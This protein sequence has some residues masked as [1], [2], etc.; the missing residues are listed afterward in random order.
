[1]SEAL[2]FV[3]VGG[4]VA[5]LLSGFP[6]ALALGG[7]SILVALLGHLVN[8]VDL[9][10]LGALPGR[11]VS[12]MVNETLVAVPLFVFMGT[13]LEKSKLAEELL[14]TMGQLFGNRRGG[15]GFAVLIVGAML[16]AS[17]GIVGATVVTMGL[18]SIPAM[19]RAKYKESLSCGLVCASG[20]LA[21]LIPPSTVLIL[22]GVMVQDANTQAQLRM[23]IFSGDPLTVTDLFAA[24]LLPGL[25]LVGLYTVWMLLVAFRDRRNCPPLE[26]SDDMRDALVR[27][28]LVAMV[29]PLALIVLVLGS[30][31]SG[32][33]TAT[34]SAALGGVGA[35]VLAL[36]SGR[37]T[38]QQLSEAARSAMLISVMIYTMLIGA[39]ILSAVFRI[40]GG[41]EVVASLLTLIPGGALGATL[42]VLGIM[43]VLGFLLD[44]FE[45]IFIV[46]PIFGPALLML[47]VDPLWFG[48]AAALV[49]QTSYLTPPFGFAIFYLQG[50]VDGLKL[51]TVYRGVA[52]FVAIQ[53]FA[54]VL[55]W[56]WPGMVT[57]LPGLLNS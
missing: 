6:V 16:A 36:C 32:L 25:M 8:T 20:T 35:L 27:K 54:G 1:M 18:I 49:L 33:A 28:V 5:G 13:V 40:L 4:A 23:G 46:I 56:W 12:I 44:T 17:T 57:W 48:V 38:R 50:V 30:I 26:M 7:V 10:L 24:A 9:A 15:L 19:R 43:F 22:L 14:V 45:I 42:F 53:L 21:Q 31:L 2:L 3:L 52:P 39:T 47:G 29:P 11:L 37:F 51:S 34:E 41:E 55:I